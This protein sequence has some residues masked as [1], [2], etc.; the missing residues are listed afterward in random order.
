MGV[1]GNIATK[2]K[3]LSMVAKLVIALVIVLIIVASLHF[4]GVFDLSAMLPSS[5]FA[6]K[7]VK[8]LPE[9]F[10]DSNSCGVFDPKKMGATFRLTDCTDTVMTYSFV[11]TITGIVMTWNSDESNHRDD[12]DSI[13]VFLNDD[14]V[15]KIFNNT[16]TYV[17]VDG[18]GKWT[19]NVGNVETLSF[20][21]PYVGTLDNPITIK[22]DMKSSKPNT[23]LHQNL[24]SFVVEYY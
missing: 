4:G 11:G 13:E 20:D 7:S 2:I 1:L 10:T 6:P 21:T 3:S 19:D 12:K 18:R 16:G 9:E 8:L 5:L 24:T 22:I 15:S 14:S 23:D 17:E